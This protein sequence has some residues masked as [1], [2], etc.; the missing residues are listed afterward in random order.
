MDKEAKEPEKVEIKSPPK[1]KR[2]IKLSR[3]KRKLLKRI[4]LVRITILAGVFA[5]LWGLL[6]LIGNILGGF[7]V[8]TYF[9]LAKNFVFTPQENVESIG[10]RTNVLILGKGGEENDAP[11]LTDTIIFTSI[12][13]DGGI[14]MI[15]LPRDIWIPALRAKLNSTYYW[16]N[17]QE[18]GGGLVLAKSTVEEIVGEPVHYG[19]VIDFSAFRH[20]VDVIGGIEVQVEDAFTDERYPILGKENDEC[21]GDP[22]YACR[23]ETVRFEKGAQVMDGETALK[24]VRSRNAE[25]D[26]G[27][28]IARAKRQQ[29]V[30]SAI[31]SK[32]FSPSVIFSPSKVKELF[33]IAKE[34]I[35]TDISPAA[36]AIIARRAIQSKGDVNSYVLDGEFLENPPTSPRYDNLYVFVS[37]AE[38]WSEVHEW[39]EEVLP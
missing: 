36:G 4:W 11:D 3:I 17:Q 7:G 15:S 38:D 35:E 12:S 33:E 16:G 26:E 20:A 31:Q 27:T 10:G 5:T 30:I 1:S 39:I 23:Y 34:N 21:G 18:D 24:F 32:I 37:I 9:A 22:E 6:L 19:I 14:T 25:G 13:H 28:D 8:G 2:D 29:K